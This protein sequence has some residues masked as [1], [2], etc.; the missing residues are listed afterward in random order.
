MNAACGSPNLTESIAG[1]SRSAARATSGEWNAP[2]TFSL[3][4]RRAPSSEAF[5]QQLV[6]GVV[7]AGDDD[8]AGTVVVRGPHAEDLPAE[9]LDHLVVEPEDRGHRAGPLLRRLGHRQAALA[10]ERDRLLDA[11]RLAAAI[12]ANSPTECP[13]T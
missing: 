3:T 9:P 2:E 8:L 6:D 11:Y 10:D 4:V 1:R 5:A 7:L 12:A 13:I